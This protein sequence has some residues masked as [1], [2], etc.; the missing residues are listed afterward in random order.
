MGGSQSDPMSALRPPLGPQSDW[1]VPYLL[2]SQG[3]DS[4]WSGVAPVWAAC[5]LP[6]MWSC[7][8]GIWPRAYQ[9]GWIHKVQR[10]GRGKL[11]QLWCRWSPA[12]EALQHQEGGRPIGRMDPQKYNVG[13]LHSASKFG[14]VNWFPL[15]FWLGGGRGQWRWPVHLFPAELNSVFRGSTPLPPSV[16][17]P[18]RFPSRA[19]DL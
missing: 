5:T 9:M 17:S 16:L 7:F 11:S 6:G 1:C 18:S 14:A 8:N 10:G 4:L 19:V 15:E 2:L 3:Q 13:R 12:A